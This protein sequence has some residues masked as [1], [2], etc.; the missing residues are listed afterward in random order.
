[1]ITMFSDEIFPL[2][3]VTSLRSGGLSWE[4]K[5]VGETLA[6]VG[7]GLFLFQFLCFQPCLKRFFQKGQKDILV[8][9]LFLVAITMPLLPFLGDGVIR[10]TAWSSPSVEKMINPKKNIILFIAVCSSILLF[11]MPATATFTSI[12]MVV[13]ASVDT[14]KRGTLNGL[15]MT[16]GSIGYGV[17]PILGSMLYALAIELAYGT[18]ADQQSSSD[19]NSSS[20]PMMVPV[21]GRIIFF[22]G[23]FLALL[24]AGYVWKY[25]QIDW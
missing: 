2:Y 22:F 7:I 25:V 12:T 10:L 24:L 13:N 3:A 11:K 16:A 17:G 4:M 5:E 19:N 14:T 8:K 6:V 18:S 20:L 1:M 15:M 9:T 21:D 23:S